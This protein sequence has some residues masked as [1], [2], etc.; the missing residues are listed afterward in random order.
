MQ[1]CHK[2]ENKGVCRLKLELHFVW[3][4]LCLFLYLFI[5]T[6]FIL[7]ISIL[8]TKSFHVVSCPG[9][10]GLHIIVLQSGNPGSD[11]H[12]HRNINNKF[13]K[14]WFT[15]LSDQHSKISI[16]E[17]S[18]LGCIVPL[19]VMVHSYHSSLIERYSENIIPRCETKRLLID[20]PLSTS[21]EGNMIRPKSIQNQTSVNK[22]SQSLLRQ[23]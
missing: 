21:H 13:G 5:Q 4:L 12:K 2:A 10:T 1:Q 11:Q 20:V 22:V 19:Y 8:F 7:S 6:F 23:L 14:T 16:T 18:K 3:I 15:Q 17:L 9:F